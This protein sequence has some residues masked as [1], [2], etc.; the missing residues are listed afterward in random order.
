MGLNLGVTVIDLERTRPLRP[1]IV[2]G[3]SGGRA[4]KKLEVH[5]GDRAMTD[6]RSDT[7]VSGITTTN[8]NDL[9]ALCGD[10]VSILQIRVHQALGVLC[11]ELHRIHH[12]I[13]VSTWNWQVTRNSSADCHNKCI[14]FSLQILVSNIVADSNSTFEFDSFIL[15][16]VDSSANQRFLDIVRSRNRKGNTSNFMFGIPYINKPPGS[17]ARS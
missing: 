16:E 1:G 17:G 4:L 12:T 10:V 3:T 7:I 14:A 8:D 6:R 13:E 11:Q 15:H 2:G 5:N 9:L